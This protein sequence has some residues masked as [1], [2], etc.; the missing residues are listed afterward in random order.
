MSDVFMDL[1]EY[2]PLAL[3][4]ARNGLEADN[5]EIMMQSA[6][7]VDHFCTFVYQRTK[8]ESKETT[9][10]LNFITNYPAILPE[11]MYVIM[12]IVLFEDGKSFWVYVKPLFSLILINPQAFSDCK[13]QLLTKVAF[14]RQEKVAQEFEKLLDGIKFNLDV[15]N[16]DKFSDNYNAFRREI[17]TLV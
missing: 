10:I 2:I 13:Q 5:T 3:S 7:I 16:R 17:K 1:S 4:L 8:K 14:D 9:Q 11:I 6:Q 12:H 15:R